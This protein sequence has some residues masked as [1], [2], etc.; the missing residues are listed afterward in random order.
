MKKQN[1]VCNALWK[2]FLDDSFQFN[3][4]SIPAYCSFVLIASS[5]ISVAEISSRRWCTSFQ[6]GGGFVE[7]LS[8]SEAR[9]K[10]YLAPAGLTNLMNT[11]YAN[12]VVQVLHN[13]PEL[14]EGVM[15]YS[16]NNN[17]GGT[18][19]ALVQKL[20][21]TFSDLDKSTEAVRP[22]AFINVSVLGAIHC[23]KF[24]AAKCSDIAN[25]VCTSSKTRKSSVPTC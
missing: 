18:P 15:S 3:A 21:D 7:N 14:K 22:F 13:I 11:C 6:L 2:G 19:G 24:V 4:V 12:S 23:R 9:S 1:I 5:N 16:L 17:P 10:G 20:R 8:E 25:A